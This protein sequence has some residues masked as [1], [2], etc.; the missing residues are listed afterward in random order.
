VPSDLPGVEAGVRHS[1]FGLGFM[2]GPIRGKNVFIPLDYLIGEREYAGRGWEMM[3]SCLSLGR[4]LSLPALSSGISQ[5]VTRTSSAYAVIRQQFNVS[6]GVFEGVQSSLARVVGLT[7]LTESVRR[8]TASAV[9]EG[10]RPSVASA[11]AKYHLTEIAQRVV[12]DAMDIHGGAAVQIG[13]KNLLSNIYLATQMNKAVEGA[14]IL[15]RSLIVF[16]QGVRR[17]HPYL[18]DLIQAASKSVN[19]FHKIFYRYL[20]FALKAFFRGIWQGITGGHLIAVPEHPCAAQI[21]QLSRMSNVLLILTEVSLLKLGSQLKRREALSARLGDILSYLYLSASAIK[22]F[23][24]EGRCEDDLPL[25]EWTLSYCLHHLQQALDDFLKNFPSK[26]LAKLLEWVLFPWGLRYTSPCDQLSKSLATKVQQDEQWRKYL[27][28]SC[29]AGQPSDVISQ[30]DAA[31]KAILS[32]QANADQLR[33][34]VIEVDEF[35]ESR[36]HGN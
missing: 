34:A 22:R 8:F 26:R 17:C 29:Y 27:T 20:R 30:L 13:P 33:D 19:A 11:I 23:E 2:N 25:L 31:L 5:T 21:K 36:A 1:S 32:D 4:G 15:T 35:G 9:A 6:I 10:R 28:S 12:I 7:Y 16:G 3:L 18:K 14:N 24:D